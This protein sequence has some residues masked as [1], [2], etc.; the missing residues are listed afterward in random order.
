MSERVILEQKHNATKTKIF[1][2]SMEEKHIKHLIKL[3]QDPD[4][5][6]LMGW[7]PFFET[8]QTK[9]FIEAISC[10]ALPYS[11]K[12][13]PIIFGIYLELEN[14]P[15]GYAVLKGLNMELLTAE[16]GL[17]VLERKYRKRGYGRLGLKCIVNYAFNELN[18]ETIGAAILSSNIMSINM[19][20]KIGFFV[21]KIMPKSW[22]MPDGSLADMLWME[23]K[24]F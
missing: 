7:D 13:Q 16:V 14:F 4:L 18:I 6:N 21:E 22:S 3:A 11:R 24:H 23:L 10:F 5:S 20:K 9:Q 19:C 8:N 1:L 2:T 15:I 17:A 12:S